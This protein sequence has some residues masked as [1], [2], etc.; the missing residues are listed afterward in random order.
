MIEPMTGEN[1]GQFVEMDFGFQTKDNKLKMA[2]N[3]L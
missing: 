2:G 1:C 3:G